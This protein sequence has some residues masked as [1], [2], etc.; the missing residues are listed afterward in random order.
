MGN[1]TGLLSINTNSARTLGVNL[2][3]LTGAQN[4]PKTHART[5]T[6]HSEHCSV[7]LTFLDITAHKQNNVPE[8][9][10]SA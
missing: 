9:I 4:D 5:S 8:R 3:L 7:D 6:L 2:Q 1:V 10:R